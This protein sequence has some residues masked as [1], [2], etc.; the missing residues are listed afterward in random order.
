MIETAL[1]LYEVKKVIGEKFIIG[2]SDIASLVFRFGQEENG[3]TL[4]ELKFDEDNVYFAK[5]VGE[6]KKINPHKYKQVYDGKFWLII[7]DEHDIT[8]KIFAEQIKVFRIKGE[9]FALLIQ[10]INP[11]K[12]IYFYS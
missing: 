7:S 4:S 6:E 2:E 3:K 1:N 8:A 12:R 5:I 11:G 9:P 10:L